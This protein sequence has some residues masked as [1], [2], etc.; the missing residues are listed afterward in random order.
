MGIGRIGNYPENESATTPPE[1]A[2]T[3]NESA[4]TRPATRQLRRPRIGNY[5]SASQQLAPAN[6]QL[7]ERESATTN[8]RISNYP[9]G[10]WKLRGRESKTTPRESETT[11]TNRKLCQ[12]I[13]NYVSESETTSPRFGN[14]VSESA[15]T[16][17]Q[18]TNTPETYFRLP[19]PLWLKW[20][21]HRAR[22]AE[23]MTKEPAF[24]SAPS[25]QEQQGALNV[26]MAPTRSLNHTCPKA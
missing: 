2:T 11:P 22:W 4:T 6:Q 12:R 19:L 1:S 3:S 23:S 26:S 16:P 24:I 18:L 5:G 14:Y 9:A 10:N 20:R 25:R 21:N 13:G 17:L 8:R 7:R 15:T